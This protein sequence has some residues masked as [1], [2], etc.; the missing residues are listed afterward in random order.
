MCFA[1]MLSPLVIV[2]STFLV[3][4]GAMC[5]APFG[6]GIPPQQRQECVVRMPPAVL[7]KSGSVP[8]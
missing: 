5:R 4:A 7:V 2:A 1:A 3:I 6:S 8:K